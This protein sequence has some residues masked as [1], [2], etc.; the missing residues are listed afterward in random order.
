MDSQRFDGFLAF[1]ATS[2]GGRNLRPVCEHLRSADTYVEAEIVKKLK[3]HQEPDPNSARKQNHSK[4]KKHKALQK[5]SDCLTQYLVKD[6]PEAMLDLTYRLASNLVFSRQYEEAMDL[7]R[8][9]FAMAMERENFQMVINLW[10]LVDVMNIQPDWE[11]ITMEEAITRNINLLQYMAIA[12]SLDRLRKEPEPVIRNLNLSQVKENPLLTDPNQALS[13]RAKFWFL[14]VN[15]VCRFYLEEFEEGIPYQQDLAAHIQAHPWIAQHPEYGIA[16]ELR[17][18]SQILDYTRRGDQAKKVGNDLQ[19]LS[20]SSLRAT[21]EQI[22]QKHPFSLSFSI[23][24]GDQD[25][26]S[27]AYSDFL[28]LLENGKIAFAPSFVTE[29]LYWCAYFCI[30]TKNGM[31]AAK[32]FAKLR[33]YSKNDFKPKRFI[34]VKFL[35]II[36]AIEGRDP[37]A[38]LQFIKNLKRSSLEDLPGIYDILLFLDREVKQA[39]NDPT[40]QYPNKMIPIPIANPP[41]SLLASLMGQEV[42]RYFDF[43]GWLQSRRLGLPLMNFHEQQLKASNEKTIDCQ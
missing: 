8:T 12:K 26:A 24:S 18:H 7:A 10:H 5:L 30:A 2:P 34:M 9:V 4:W 15:A 31:A 23:E 40:W 16:K 19:Y 33:K 22:L 6:E 14:R 13:L 42:L 43:L 20:F 3:V 28:A 36:D 32:I 17:I 27:H 39:V 21:E 41:A 1:I 38:A 37:S 11:F 29:N 25:N 35:E